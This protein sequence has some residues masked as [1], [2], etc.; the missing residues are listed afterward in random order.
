MAIRHLEEA[1]ML[2]KYGKLLGREKISLRVI[3]ICKKVAKEENY[4]ESIKALG[5]LKAL[6]ISCN[7]D[8]YWSEKRDM[9]YS[10]ELDE[11]IK[12]LTNHGKT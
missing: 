9:G 3:E 2:Q 11:A 12:T 10:K 4:K 6:A 5:Q 1:K 8:C 7:Y